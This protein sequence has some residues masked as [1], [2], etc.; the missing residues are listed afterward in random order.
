M[1]ETFE[2][3]SHVCMVF[4]RLGLSLYDFLRKNSY[5]PFSIDVVREFGRQL[6]EAVACALHRLFPASIFPS[7]AASVPHSVSLGSEMRLEGPSSE[8]GK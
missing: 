4:E 3:R 1:L 5:R 6:L 2:H 8:R 7:C